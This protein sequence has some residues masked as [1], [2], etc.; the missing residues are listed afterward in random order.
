MDYT[1]YFIPTCSHITLSAFSFC[2]KVNTGNDLFTTSREF[3][4][5]IEQ[6]HARKKEQ[7]QIKLLNSW[8]KTDRDSRLKKP[9]SKNK[10]KNIM[11]KKIELFGVLLVMPY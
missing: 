1:G 5:Q 10:V 9:K 6:K 8:N 7:N 11:L 3:E 4:E 2:I